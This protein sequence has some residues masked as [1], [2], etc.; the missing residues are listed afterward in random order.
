MSVYRYMP[1]KPLNT[2]ERRF[3]T[4]FEEAV[5][6]L[7]PKNHETFEEAKQRMIGAVRKYADDKDA[8]LHSLVGDR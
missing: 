1:T 7:D 4:A 6:K 8:E 3:A 5:V 2:P